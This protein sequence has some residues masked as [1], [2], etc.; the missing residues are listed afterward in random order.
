M[1]NAQ[2]WKRLLFFL[3][4]LLSA[5]VAFAH[6][7]TSTEQERGACSDAALSDYCEFTDHHERL[8]R[9]TCRSF[10][11]VLMCVRNQPFVDRPAEPASGPAE[12]SN[13][14]KLIIPA[15][16]LAVLVVAYLI[17]RKKR[18]NFS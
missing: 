8:H 1:S 9:G 11:E 17:Q 13:L 6:G 10:D 4:A 2:T 5:Q 7:G 18:N 15:I 14:S 12:D 3:T 16:A